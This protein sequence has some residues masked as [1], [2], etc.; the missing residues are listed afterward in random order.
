MLEDRIVGKERRCFFELARIEQGIE[1]LNQGMG[2]GHSR[3]SLRRLAG[4]RFRAIG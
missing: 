4:R 3:F 1:A 2:I